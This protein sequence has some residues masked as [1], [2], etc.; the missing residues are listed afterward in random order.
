[1]R[2]QYLCPNCGSI[3]ILI[4]HSSMSESEFKQSLPKYL[5]CYYENCL[6]T[7]LPVDETVRS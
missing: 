2:Q 1:M 5:I 6:S 4:K 7:M 3:K